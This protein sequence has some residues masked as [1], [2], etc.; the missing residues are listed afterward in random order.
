[1]SGMKHRIS[2]KEIDEALAYAEHPSQSLG[3]VAIYLA[4]ALSEIIPEFNN[5]VYEL[6][7]G[8]CRDGVNVIYVKEEIRAARNL[9][10]RSGFEYM[11][12]DIVRSVMVDSDRAM[13]DNALLAGKN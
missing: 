3:K 7:R 10:R 11:V 6:R 1:M 12:L 2:R 13:L 8:V 9:V 4:R 5:A